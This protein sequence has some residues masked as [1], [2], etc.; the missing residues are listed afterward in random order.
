MDFRDSGIPEVRFFMQRIYKHNIPLLPKIV[1]KTIRVRL[2]AV[3][4]PIREKTVRSRF[5][6]L[7]F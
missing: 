4:G 6:A 2:P 3:T 7:F 5:A 1:K